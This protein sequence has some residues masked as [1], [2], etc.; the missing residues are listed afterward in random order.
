MKPQN[1]ITLLIPAYN[2]APTL[3]EV[4]RHLQ[5]L[6]IPILVVDDGS[7]DG[8]LA[9]ATGE[10]VW[11]VV[12]H[13]HNRGKGAALKTGFHEAGEAGFTHV[14]TFDADGQHPPGAIP[15]FLEACARNEDA[16]LVGNR[17]GDETIGSMP[18]VRRLS[19]GLSSTL[20]SL[21]AHTPIPDAQCGMRI[22][23]LWI[24]ESMVLESDGYALETEVLVKAGQ[25]GIE[26]EN[27]PIS[28][29]YPSGTSTSR[30]R[31]FA[32]SWRI[33]KVVVRSLREGS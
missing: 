9:A 5:P 31:A 18:W 20:I 26:V 19:N 27:I 22:Y 6:S 15:A 10:Q 32:D 33:T 21:A 23:P 3:G 1:T 7:T 14:L 13:P 24:F 17:F 29:Q 2:A 25:H 28:C 30:Y 11:K 8:T 4:L 12:S 16:I